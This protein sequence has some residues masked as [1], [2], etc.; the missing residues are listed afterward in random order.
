MEALTIVKINNNNEILSKILNS[1]A[2]K[3]DCRIEF[4]TET[5]KIYSH[6]DE[7]VKLLVLEETIG[8]LGLN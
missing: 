1:V 6:C 7:N 2:A 5:R 3:H 8:I 4:D